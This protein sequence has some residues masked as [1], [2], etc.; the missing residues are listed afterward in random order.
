MGNLQEFMEEWFLQLCTIHSAIPTVLTVL[1]GRGGT[2]NLELV[3]VFYPKLGN[4]SSFGL[5][6]FQTSQGK[7]S[8]FVLENLS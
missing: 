4:M 3:Y 2:G 7:N 8:N 1:A 5:V 6:P